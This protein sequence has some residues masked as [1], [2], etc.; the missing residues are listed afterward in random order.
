[1]LKE[2]NL[3]TSAMGEIED[4]ERELDKATADYLEGKISLEEYRAIYEQIPG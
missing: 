1:M 3:E 2:R 4:N